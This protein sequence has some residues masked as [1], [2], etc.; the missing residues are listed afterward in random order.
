MKDY[1]IL[2]AD[3]SK[4]LSEHVRAAMAEGWVPHGGV[5]HHG[6]MPSPWAQAMV[7]PDSANPRRTF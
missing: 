2:V 6:D 4:K 7:L 1:M 5:S 3:R